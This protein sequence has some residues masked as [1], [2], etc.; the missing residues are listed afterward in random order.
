MKTNFKDLSRILPGI[1]ISLILL[2]VVF[3]EADV[4][5]LRKEL[6][7]ANL[8]YIYVAQAF[9]LFSLFART[10]AWRN[11]LEDKVDSKRVFFTLMEGYFINNVFPFR[12]GEI[13]RALLLSQTT[14]LRF[15]QVIPTIVIERAFDMLI[16][17][18]I[19]L[20][21]LPFVVGVEGAGGKAALVGG[22][23]VL[24][25]VVLYLLA[26]QRKRVLA[27]YNRLQER[28]PI[29][30]K[31]AVSQLATFF[32]GLAVLTRAGRFI[33]VF[34]WMVFTWALLIVHYYLVLLAFV[35]D[36]K[37]V[38]ATFG[39]STVGL[40]IAVPSAP[41]G[42]GVVEATLV[43]V[44][45]LFA[46]GRAKALAYSLVVHAS[47]LLLTSLPGMY[48]L[49]ADGESLVQVYRQV[50]EQASKPKPVL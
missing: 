22:L 30:Q 21:S 2:V 43:F 10:K 8:S 26:H 42:L 45:G 36:A 29:L 17:V 3:W 48:G 20:A 25:L 49:M 12:M 18:S 46:I 40:G 4:D 38:W 11:L 37:V 19:F 23:V 47:Y 39:I 50:R 28:I 15:W 27:I 1:F 16:V 14:S 41:G 6:A 13:G 32:D 34:C 24:G 33:R 31:I 35:P 7:Q 44:F 9:F 5:E